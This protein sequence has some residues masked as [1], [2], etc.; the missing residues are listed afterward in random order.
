[1]VHVVAVL[2][3]LSAINF[4]SGESRE[5]VQILEVSTFPSYTERP[6]FQHCLFKLLQNANNAGIVFHF[7]TNGEVV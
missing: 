6:H 2:L 4:I 3:V 7:K 1:M 5:T